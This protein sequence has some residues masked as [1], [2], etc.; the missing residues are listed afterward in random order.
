MNGPSMKTSMAL[1]ST[2]VFFCSMTF[3]SNIH[4][5]HIVLISLFQFT[6]L[7]NQQLSLN[8]QQIHWVCLH[9][10]HYFCFEWVSYTS[11]FTF[12]G[13]AEMVSIEQLQVKKNFTLETRS[14]TE[15][16][17]GRAL[18]WWWR[19]AGGLSTLPLQA[20]AALA[21][22]WRTQNASAAAMEPTRAKIQ[23]HFS[24]L[25]LLK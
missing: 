23:R 12:A 6:D 13:A 9:F 4:F 17:R 18:G 16:C 2:T 25:K 24:L 5:S 10:I 8:G 3:L 7:L 15:W 21:L 11:F 14:W 20:A 19:L 22:Q 1:S